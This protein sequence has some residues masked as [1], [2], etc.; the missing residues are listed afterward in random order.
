M[1][2][3]RQAPEPVCGGRGADGSSVGG[4]RGSLGILVGTGWF[5]RCVFA[6]CG[7]RLWEAQPAGVRWEGYPVKA[8]PVRLR[9]D[10]LRGSGVPGGSR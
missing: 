9:E 3:P 8:F 1:A 5:G 7:S 4:G 2:G 10:G 6:S